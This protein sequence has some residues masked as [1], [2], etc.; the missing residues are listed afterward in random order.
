MRDGV[1]R[2]TMSRDQVRAIAARDIEAAR[3]SAQALMDAG[4]IPAP[5][6]ALLQEDFQ[7]ACDASGQ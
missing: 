5:D 7:W 1:A 3:A 2:L 6:Q 4:I